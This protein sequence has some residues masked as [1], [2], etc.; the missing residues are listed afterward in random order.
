MF[1]SLV[2]VLNRLFGGL[3]ASAASVPGGIMNI[4][5]VFDA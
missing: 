5:F 2:V 4:L 3:Q 1:M